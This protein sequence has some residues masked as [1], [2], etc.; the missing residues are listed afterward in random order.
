MPPP[1]PTRRSSD[2]KWTRPAGLAP[3]TSIA[4]WPDGHLTVPA[5]RV[6]RVVQRSDDPQASDRM[7]DH[8]VRPRLDI[9]RPVKPNGAAVILAPGGGYRYV[10]ID[11]EGYELARWLADRKSTRMNSSP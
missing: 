4:L 3:D 1:F 7:L 10:V 2:L 5:G 6:E 9:F 11:K 8:I